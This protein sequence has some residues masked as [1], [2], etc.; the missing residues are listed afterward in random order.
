MDYVPGKEVEAIGLVFGSS[1]QST[2][3]GKDISSAVRGLIG[4]ELTEYKEVIDKAREK[5]LEDM[6]GKAILLQADAV[7]AIRFV[8]STVLSGAVEIMASG[9]AVK[10]K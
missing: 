1:I 9:T 8:S 4:R 3:I 10:F 5:A 6:V 7:I 2:H